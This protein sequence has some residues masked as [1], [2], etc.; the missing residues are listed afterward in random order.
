MPET[1]GVWGIDIGLAGLKA[2]VDRPVPRAGME[3]FTVHLMGTAR[4]SADPTRGVTDSF[5]AYGLHIYQ[6]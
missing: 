3:L 1:R 2:I 4:M 5:G 6:V